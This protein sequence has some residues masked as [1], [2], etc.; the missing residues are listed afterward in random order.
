MNAIQDAINLHGFDEVIISTL[1]AR[2]SKWLKLDLPS[3]VTGLGLPVTTVTARD[4]DSASV[5]AGDALGPGEQVAQRRAVDQNASSSHGRSPGAKARTSVASGV[6]ARLAR[7]ASR[8]RRRARR[9]P[10]RA[11]RRR[12]GRASVDVDLELLARLAPRGVLDRLA[13]VDEARRGTSTARRPGRSRGAAARCGRPARAGS[14]RRRA[15]GC[16]RRRS[17]SARSAASGGSRSPAPAPQRGQNRR[18][19]SAGLMLS[20]WKCA[21]ASWSSAW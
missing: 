17:R 13:E 6:V 18:P 7:A 11:S 14:R 20:G 8:R 9:G 12:R 4:R 10:R 19:S 2:V 16:R 21:P 1:P 15:W 3:K 5:P